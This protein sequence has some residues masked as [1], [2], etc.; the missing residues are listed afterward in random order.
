MRSR[1]LGIDRD[2]FFT[3]LWTGGKARFMNMQQKFFANIQPSWPS[4]SGKK[5]IYHMA[6]GTPV[7]CRTQQAI[8]KGQYSPILPLSSQLQCKMWF[9]LPTCTT[10][11]HVIKLNFSFSLLVGLHASSS[12]CYTRAWWRHKN[13]SVWIWWVLSLIFFCWI[14]K[15]TVQPKNNKNKIRYSPKITHA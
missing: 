6:Y 8:K 9:I 11:S 5:R 10:T 7:P 2:L 4:K 15:Y 12:G 3:C 13:A 14:L 1:W